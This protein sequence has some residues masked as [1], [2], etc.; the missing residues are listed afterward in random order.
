MKIAVFALCFFA[1]AWPLAGAGAQTATYQT[2]QAGPLSLTFAQDGTVSGTYP[3]YNGKL[4][5]KLIGKDRIEGTWWQT[6]GFSDDVKCDKET[7]G[8]VY[9][10][11]FVLLE[12]ADEK[13]FHGMWGSCDEEPDEAWTG[14][15]SN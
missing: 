12:D 13:G 1:L 14:K 4:Q 15:L 9:W 7:K 8:T 3:Q 5:G 11:K 6:K 2:S 10:G